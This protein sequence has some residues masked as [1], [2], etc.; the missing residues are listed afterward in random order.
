MSE[1]SDPLR[2]DASPEKRFFIRMLVKDIELIPAVLDLVDNSVDGALALRG[3][4]S[5]KDLWVRLDVSP[6]GFKISDNCGGIDLDVA[7]SYA[8]RF[9]RPAEF[10]GIVGSIGQFG[11]GMKRA[12]FKL[13]SAFAVE[14]RTSN[15]SFSLSVDVDGWAAEPGHDWTF[16]FQDTNPDYSLPDG[17]QAGT[18]ITVSPLHPSV[19]EDFGNSSVIGALRAQLRLRHRSALDR[20]VLMVLNGDPL[21]SFLPAL[22]SSDTIAPIYRAFSFDET[23]EGVQGT[24]NVKLYAGIVPGER[25]GDNDVDEGD[26]EQFRSDSDAGWYVFCNQRLLIAADR[27]SLTGWGTAAPAYHPQYRR[28]RG[29][30]FLESAAP[31]LLPW[32]TT[33][34]GVDQ[35]SRVW[36]KVAPEMRIALTN[37]VAV[38]NRVK[39]ERQNAETDQERPITVALEGARPVPLRS[40]TTQTPVLR[41]PTPP[42]QVRARQPATVR[43]VQYT[44]DRDKYERV[45]NALGA[46]NTAEVGRGTFDYYYRHQIDEDD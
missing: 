44:V 17:E 27:T 24:V 10:Q 2:V 25:A 13:G 7:R 42:P 32:N 39:N 46:A 19:A 36:R 14:S 4:E 45:A 3:E 34:T 18:E 16:R 29:Y 33:K 31:E 6:E 37:V 20:G 26:A 12:L 11:V 28:F 9:G 41:F 23:V 15:T 43:K 40:I 22:Q 1:A 30:L 21:T 35:D 38:L 5:F 8:F